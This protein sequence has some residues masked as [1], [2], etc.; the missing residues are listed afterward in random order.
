MD[1]QPRT[2][3][4]GLIARWW[5]EFNTASPEELAFYRSAV[6]T[7]GQPA[8]DLS[9]GAGRLLIPL[10]AEGLDV[11]GVD[12]SPDMLAQA[13]ALARARGLDPALHAAALHQMDLPRRYRTI[14]CCD[15]FGLGGNRAHDELA[16]VRVYEHLEPGGTFVFN[17]YLPYDEVD[18][19]RWAD[20]LPE[21]RRR[22]ASPWPESGDRRTFADGDEIELLG[23][24]VD[25]D[26]LLQRYT[27]EMRAMLRR[28]G[29]VIATEE[30]VLQENLYFAQELQLM[31]RAAGFVDIRLEG[32]YNG[33][34]V[35]A[36]DSTVVF[37]ARRPSA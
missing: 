33:R 9:C 21:H 13:G 12:L 6:E 4:Y 31:L 22:S 16:L 37:L 29:E 23:R 27:R 14:Y 32:L 17:H 36:D 7:Y 3:H 24:Y 1:G 35:T 30:N 26:P 2:W 10:A 34:P 28:G 20:W 8:L 11:D 15:S 18:K 5:A 19:D 25:F